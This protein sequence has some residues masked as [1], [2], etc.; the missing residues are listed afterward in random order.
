LIIISF[1]L[2][3]KEVIFIEEIVP[4]AGSVPLNNEAGTVYVLLELGLSTAG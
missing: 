3:G 4:A 1:A 2:E